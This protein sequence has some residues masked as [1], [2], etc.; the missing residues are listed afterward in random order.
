V[1]PHTGRLVLPGVPTRTAAQRRQPSAELTSAKRR[2]QLRV[3]HVGSRCYQALVPWF[4]S[5]CPLLPCPASQ[6]E[7]LSLER[8]LASAALSTFVL[9]LAG[10]YGYT[11]PGPI[12]IVAYLYSGEV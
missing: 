11:L 8:G 5:M 9:R 12:R 10:P 2:E 7:L 6:G 4:G 1:R 3:Q